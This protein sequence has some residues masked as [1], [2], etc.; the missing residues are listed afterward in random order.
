MQDHISP[1]YRDKYVS[2]RLLLQHR[3]RPHGNFLGNNICKERLLMNDIVS[4]FQELSLTL[5]QTM[6]KMRFSSIQPQ[7]I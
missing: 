7:N 6:I 4:Y 1:F 2:N 3:Q 5:G